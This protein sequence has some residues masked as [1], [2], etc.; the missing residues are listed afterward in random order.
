MPKYTSTYKDIKH[1]EFCPKKPGLLAYNAYIPRWIF[2]V[3]IYFNLFLY[4]VYLRVVYLLIFWVAC[5]CEDLPL[6]PLEMLVRFPWC[7]T[8]TRGDYN[9]VLEKLGLRALKHGLS[10]PNT[11]LFSALLPDL[12]CVWRSL[13]QQWAGCACA[14]HPVRSCRRKEGQCCWLPHCVWGWLR[15][16][17]HG[18]A[19]IW[20]NF[21][22]GNSSPKIPT[23][24]CAHVYLILDIHNC[25][26]DV[27][28]MRQLVSPRIQVGIHV[29]K[30]NPVRE[31][32]NLYISP[33]PNSIK[34]K[35][36]DSYTCLTAQEAHL[37][38][39]L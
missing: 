16:S 9:S 15:E 25:L 10:V 5:I 1:G 29:R 19:N 3:Y 2:L 39:L 23:S 6:S 36:I 14:L 31:Q 8:A 7:H 22:Q 32:F 21:Q 27:L 24:L 13:T 37:V 20:P 33:T 11:H 28:G 34:P 30:W 35:L 12:A 38:I 4:S 18:H 26:S 17:C